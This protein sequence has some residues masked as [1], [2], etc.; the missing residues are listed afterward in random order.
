MHSR[1]GGVWCRAVILCLA[2]AVSCKTADCDEP[3]KS[4]VDELVKQLGSDD[5]ATRKQAIPAL[6]AAGLPAV[7]PL[8]TAAQSGDLE[9]RFHAV[10]ILAAISRT[11]DEATVAA[12]RKALEVVAA[13]KHPDASGPAKDALKFFARP[14]LMRKLA[15]Q[16]PLAEV[17]DGEKKKLSIGDKPL[18]RFV[19]LDRYNT[20]GTLWAFGKGRPTA[21][22]E[23]YPA[24]SG[25]EEDTWYTAIA[26]LSEL[27]L[28]SESIDG[29]N[30]RDWAPD[31]WQGTFQ[32]IPKSP[33]PAAGAQERLTEMQILARRFTAHQ[34]WAPGETRYELDVLPSPVLRYADEAAKILDGGMFLIVH[35]T[36]PEV[37]LLIEAHPA[38]G[39]NTWK[40]ALAPLG[41][42]RMHVELDAEEVWKC[43][44]PKNV[45]GGGK[46]PYWVFPRV[47]IK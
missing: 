12:A 43:P 1:F 36:N 44:T 17:H 28:S 19:D 2:V 47:L 9:L 14:D 23:V 11:T 6:I 10:A 3:K 32:D 33:N 24:G 21:V 34:F 4:D 29:V 15:L 26:S 45:V 31:P 30:G 7:Q 38:K 40:Y 41:S 46:H 39:Q 16:F 35:D 20:D 27:S 13:S 18:H 42:A 37:V 8:E 22:M 5:L 25:T